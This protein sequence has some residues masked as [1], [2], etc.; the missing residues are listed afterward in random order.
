M[1]LSGWTDPEGFG[2]I[3]QYAHEHGWHLEMRAYF[4]GNL[5]DHWNGDGILYVKGN[6]EEIDRFVI[7]QATRCPVVALNANLPANLV[8]PIVTPDNAEAGRMAARHLIERGQR[9]L[10]FYSG[11]GGPVSFERQRGF[12]ETV[13]EAGYR[14]HTLCPRRGSG[15]L[16]AWSAERRRLADDLRKL[17]ARGGVLA[18]DDLVAADLID[19]AIES[20]RRVPEDLAVV[21]LGNLAPVC[22][23]APIPITSID[24]RAGEVARAGADL[25]GRLMAGKKARSAPVLVAPGALIVRESSDTTIV[26]DPRLA[27]AVAFI[28]AHVRHAPSLEQIAEASGISRRTLYHLFREDL[29]ISPATYIRRQRSQL[30][31]RLL[32]EQPELTRDEAARLAGFTSTRTLSRCLAKG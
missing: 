31:D 28:Q 20:G 10:A 12:E 7:R 13:R 30:A 4:T 11:L 22:Q 18:L 6:R 27:T 17:P 8:V 15:K 32:R 1:L 16:A 14:L 26:R 25:L 29:G 24:L 3:S 21:G 9:D 19:V 5:P 2:A 23:C